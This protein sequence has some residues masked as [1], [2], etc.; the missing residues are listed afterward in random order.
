MSIYSQYI[1]VLA[2]MTSH[3]LPVSAITSPFSLSLTDRYLR[4]SNIKTPN[5]SFIFHFIFLFPQ[6]DRWGSAIYKIPS[7]FFFFTFYLLSPSAWLIDIWGSAIY[8]TPNI[9]FISYFISLFPQGRF[10]MICNKFLFF[11][12]FACSSSNIKSCPKKKHNF[13]CSEF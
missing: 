2:R 10:L 1:H 13:S 5:I 12:S 4:I 6:P 9:F 7:N 11:I 3:C 8:K